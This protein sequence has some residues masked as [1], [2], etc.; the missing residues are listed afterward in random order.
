[1]IASTEIQNK[2]I[3]LYKVLREYLWD[4]DT[5]EDL[6]DVEV[7]IF[8]TFIDKSKLDRAMYKLKKDIQPTLSDDEDMEKACIELEEAIAKLDDSQYAEIYNT[9]LIKGEGYR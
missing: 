4:V 2:Y 5:L 3:K 8:T 7:E 9:A 1:M 6:S